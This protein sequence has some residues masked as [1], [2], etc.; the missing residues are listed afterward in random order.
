MSDAFPQ[1]SLADAITYRLLTVAETTGG[2]G[3]VLD[4][5]AGFR[6]HRLRAPS[7]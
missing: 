1:A 6:K 7:I 5:I 3:P 4:R 2:L